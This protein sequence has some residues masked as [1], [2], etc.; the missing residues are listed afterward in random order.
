[1][2]PFL[3]WAGGKRFLAEKILEILPKKINT[4]FEPFVGGGAIFFALAK[5]KRFKRVVLS[6]TNEELIITYKAIRDS[7]EDVIKHLKTLEDQYK[8]KK[9]KG[10]EEAYYYNARKMDRDERFADLD[11]SI[12]AAR[13]IFLN[14]TGFNGLWR[15]NLSG[16][17]NVPH[18]KYKNPKILDKANLLQVSKCL[19]DANIGVADFEQATYY[20]KKGDIIYLDPPFWPIKEGAFVGYNSDKFDSLDHSRL[21]GVMKKFKAKGVFA[22]QSN[23]DVEPIRKLNSTMIILSVPVPRRINSKGSGRGNV[24]ELL[25]STKP[26]HGLI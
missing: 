18:G 24:K 7:V 15:V 13:F 19:Q 8:L 23:A 11:L 26:G 1:M 5:E 17:C 10:K 21:A 9:E 16:Y 2:K 4:Y 25:I 3:K 22:L 14:R 20:A 12:R 6:D